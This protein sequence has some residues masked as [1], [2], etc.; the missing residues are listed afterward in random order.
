M[1]QLQI[2]LYAQRFKL[3]WATHFLLSAWTSS[4]ISVE[5]IKRY[6]CFDLSPATQPYEPY[7]KRA[8]GLF[9]RL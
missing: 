7:E 5:E 1:N 4:Q 6:V 2:N 8:V 9:W 3:Y